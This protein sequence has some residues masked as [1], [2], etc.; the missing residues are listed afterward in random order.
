[1]KVIKILKIL[2]IA[3]IAIGIWYFFIK[4]YNYKIT[5]KTKQTPV[6]VYNEIINWN[7]GRSK[8]EQQVVSNLKKTPFESVY[9]E[10]KNGDSIVNLNWTIKK[11]NDSIT[12]VTL[13]IKDSKNNFSQNIRALF[14][15]NAFIAKRISKVKELNNKIE[16]QSK[17]HKLS[18]IS[19]TKVP[20][21]NCAC[22]SLESD[23]SSKALTM[24]S[25]ISVLTDYAK[26]NNIELSG[27]P[28][29]EVTY[30]DTESEKIKFNFC[31]P[32]EHREKYPENKQLFFKSIKEHLAL[33][34]VFNGNY[35]MS[36]LGW[37]RI[38]DY[39]NRNNINI[40]KSI[41]EIYLNDPHQGGNPLDWEAEIYM[42]IRTQE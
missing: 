32:L 40:E 15:N 9:Q 11:E 41:I 33:K 42:P 28:F 6:I 27:H 26:N 35:N 25:N 8:R 12:V 16:E 19:K 7:D 1:M 17:R 5:F 38:L 4:D 23:L 18:S 20:F 37:Y 36:H 14:G 30:W 2:S 10:L 39:S 22:I 31:F 3:I 24:V 21:I 13:K 34:T 29:S